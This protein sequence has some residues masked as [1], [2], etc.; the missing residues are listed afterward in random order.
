MYAVDADGTVTGCVNIRDL[1]WYIVQEALFA[2]GP[3]V[4]S[5][6][7]E[8]HMNET[9]IR[10]FPPSI[11]KLTSLTKLDLSQNDVLEAVSE[12]IGEMVG[13]KV[14]KLGGTDLQELPSSIGKLTGLVILDLEWCEMLQALP[15]EIGRMVGLRTLNLSDC[16][17]KE[18][19]STIGNLTGLEQLLLTGCDQL[20]ALPEDIS[21]M[22]ALKLLNLQF[23]ALKELPSSIGKL[24]GLET[25]ALTGC[26]EL[27][28]LPGEIG[29]MVGLRRLYMLGTVFKQPLQSSIWKLTGLEDL[30]LDWCSTGFSTCTEELGEMVG[31]RLLNLGFTTRS[32]ICHEASGNEC[33]LPSSIGKLTGLEKLNLDF[34]SFF[35]KPVPDFLLP[36]E[37]GEMKRLRELSLNSSGAKELPSSIGQLTGLQK[38]SL[39][40]C[41]N[42]E[43]LPQEIGRMVGLRVLNLGGCR[44]LGDA[45]ASIITGL[46]RTRHSIRHLD[47]SLS[48]IQEGG[49]LAIGRAIKETYRASFP[50]FKIY[51]IKLSGVAAK[52]GLPVESGNADDWSNS[53]IIRWM[54][55]DFVVLD[56]VIAFL[57]AQISLVVEE[58]RPR[59]LDGSGNS[60]IPA[61]SAL[62]QDNM[63]QIGKLF[64]NMQTQERLQQVDLETYEVYS[65]TDSEYE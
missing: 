27:Y 46:L 15:K 25:L 53:R 22:V 35:L 26:H 16:G 21:A 50:P 41:R 36:E 14:L 64:M 42:I 37:I 17:L 44:R 13:L 5:G 29:G 33:E 51:G 45:G 7:T 52:L 62:G 24:T 56:T 55:G 6:L 58:Y 60:V 40:G 1:P 18:V 43:A 4:L 39:H 32:A 61:V 28:S 2:P 48:G 23:T 57:S 49:I 11:V 34:S 3:T 20:E 8:L 38:L 63:K 10:E 65:E 47:L 19:P 9:R 12:H 54:L 30:H 59:P 31:L